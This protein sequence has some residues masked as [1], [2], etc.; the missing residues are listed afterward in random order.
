QFVDDGDEVAP[1]MSVTI[2]DGNVDSNTLAATINYTSVN[3]T[4]ILQL[5]QLLTLAEGASGA[6]DASLL[7]TTDSD[8]AAAELTYSVISPT[9]VGRLESVA[10]PGVGV[11]QFTQADVNAGQLRYAHDGSETLVDTFTFIVVDASGATFGSVAFRIA[12]T[13]QNDAPTLSSTSIGPTLVLSGGAPQTIDATL[14]V[15]DPDSPLLVQAVVRISGQYMQGF[16]RLTLGGTHPL[17]AVWNAAD[18]SLTLSGAASPAA[19]AAA[20]SS[21]Q[22]S[23]SSTLA[24]TR[25]VSFV[26]SDGAAQSAAL[27]APIELSGV[28]VV[29]EP[30]AAPGVEASRPVTS[31]APVVAPPIPRSDAAPVQP[32]PNTTTDHSANTGAPN[33]ETSSSAPADPEAT[34]A[35]AAGGLLPAA[36]RTSGEGSDSSANAQADVSALVR[37]MLK[38]RVTLDLISFDVAPAPDADELADLALLLEQRLESAS[39]TLSY[40]Q[41]R[42]SLGLLDEAPADEQ[43]SGRELDFDVLADPGVSGGLLISASVLWWATRAGGLLA[44]MMASV[45][46]WRSFDPLPILA[47]SR[48]NRGETSGPSAAAATDDLAVDQINNVEAP[49]TVGT[50]PPGTTHRTM[51]EELVA[52]T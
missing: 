15:T 50:A 41:S 34:Q 45:P 6:I 42:N 24:G 39:A 23:S 21:V 26:V 3:N 10:A 37:S 46:A 20:L 48:S 29:L 16:D 51:I 4:P 14:G 12:I 7:L 25:G 40:A 47:R 49:P 32:G 52:P 5:N 1:S 33:D 44:A 13:P 9:S 11:T 35:S 43:P 38:Q 2:N 18:G 31:Q 30:P 28:N 22:F 8:D 27:G 17:S 19:Y 36:G